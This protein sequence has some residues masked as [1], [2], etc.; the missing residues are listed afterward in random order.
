[1]AK[2]RSNDDRNEVSLRGFAERVEHGST[3]SGAPACNLILVMEREGNRTKVR[4]NAYDEV[5]ENCKARVV[6][7]AR[8]VVLGELMNRSGRYAALVEVRARD[9]FAV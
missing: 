8:V 4:V 5:A 6:D 1:M 7:G 9:V 2:G 3:R